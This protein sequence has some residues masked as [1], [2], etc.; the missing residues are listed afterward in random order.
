MSYNVLASG[1]LASVTALVVGI[2]FGTL[3]G[4]EQILGLTDTLLGGW[5]LAVFFGVV[6]ALIYTQLGFSQFLPGQ[7]LVKGAVFGFLVWVVILIVGAFWA[8]VN[9]AAFAAPFTGIVLHLIWGATLALF[10]EIWPK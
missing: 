7:S 8:P 3:G 6:L 10:L 1:F 9:L 5:I 4:W 2:A